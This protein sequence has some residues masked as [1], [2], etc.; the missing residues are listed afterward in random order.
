[1][2]NEKVVGLLW[3]SFRSGNLGV[4]ALSICNLALVREEARALGVDVRFLII[5][6]SGLLNYVP[7]DVNGKVEF[8]HFSARNF[9]KNPIFIYKKIA[10]CD[11]VFDIGEGD[12]FSDIYGLSRFVKMS[13]SKMVTVLRGRRLVLSP[14]TIGPFDTRFGRM[15][16]GYMMKKSSAVVARDY[17]SRRVLESFDLPN[18]AHEAIDVAFMLPFEKVPRNEDGKI[19]FGLNV[20]GLLFHGGYNGANQFGLKC[21]Y[22]EFTLRLLRELTSIEDV[23]VHLVPHVLTEEFPV[24][25]DYHVCEELV[26]EFP[27][28]VLPKRFTSPSEAKSYISG[29]DVFAGA[30]MH[31]TVGAFSSCVPVMPL[32]YSRKFAGLF[33]SVGYKH[34][35]DMKALD[36][37]E[38]INGIKR[39]IDNRKSMAVEVLAG[40]DKAMERLKAYR[41]VVREAL[42]GV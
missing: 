4:G 42:T 11:I 36:E 28:V 12:S 31:A 26:R 24:E 2:R 23:E 5:G 17:M 10:S 6:N 32:A 15:A 14:Q 27:S 30:R 37:D 20:S 21:N 40:R 34:V 16:A 41:A 18:N 29:M 1:M 25:D 33:E 35:L 8:V 3:H 22:K 7:E 13:F 19:R 9:A 38:L 39:G